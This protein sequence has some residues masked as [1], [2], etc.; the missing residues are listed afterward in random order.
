[1]IYSRSVNNV[2]IMIIIFLSIDQ[3]CV[4]LVSMDATKTF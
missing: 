4:K 1:M 2:S 3:P